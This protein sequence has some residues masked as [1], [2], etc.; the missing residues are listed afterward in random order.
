[1]AIK[2]RNSPSSGW[3]RIVIDNYECIKVS[4]WSNDSKTEKYLLGQSVDD[5]DFF[6]VNVNDSHEGFAG[7]YNYEFDHL[8]TK[9]EAEDVHLNNIAAIDIDNHEQDPLGQYWQ[10]G[11]TENIENDVPGESIDNIDKQADKKDTSNKK[12]LRK[13]YGMNKKRNVKCAIKQEM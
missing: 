10:Y 1:M 9:K 2:Y 7:S 5:S 11:V 4:E 12:R 6:Y 8:P 13:I 3:Q